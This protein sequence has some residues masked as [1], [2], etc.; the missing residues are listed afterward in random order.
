MSTP[1]VIYADY[2]DNCHYFVPKLMEG[3][4]NVVQ[5]KHKESCERIWDIAK[6]QRNKTIIEY[7]KQRDQTLMN[8]IKQL[9][10]ALNA[11]RKKNS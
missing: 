3:N 1:S 2:C 5:C 9:E 11:E 7:A 8:K 4:F 6:D 10:D